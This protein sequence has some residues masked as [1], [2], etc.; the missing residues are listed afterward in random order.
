[1]AYGLILKVCRSIGPP[2][3]PV[4]MRTFGVMSGPSTALALECLKT[5][6]SPRHCLCTALIPPS[7]PPPVT[8]ASPP[9]SPTRA[10]AKLPHCQLL[11][12][13]YRILYQ[14]M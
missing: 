3:S 1:M 11:L 8:S 12:S 6:T 7:A 10:P 2:A 14:N 4:R 13:T 9:T 5:H